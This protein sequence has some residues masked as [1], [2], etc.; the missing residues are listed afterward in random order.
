M[1]M[2]IFINLSCLSGLYN[3][4]GKNYFIISST[5]GTFPNKFA[6]QSCERFSAHLSNV[7][8]VSTLPCETWNAHRARATIELLDKET[9]EFISS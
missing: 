7:N 6:A 8:N 5:F 4:S 9:P 2:M 1:M 3:V